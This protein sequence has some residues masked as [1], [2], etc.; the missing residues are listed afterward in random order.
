MCFENFELINYD[1]HVHLV[2]SGV[3]IEYIHILLVCCGCNDQ[4]PVLSSEN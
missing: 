2:R 1:G 3:Y 4:F